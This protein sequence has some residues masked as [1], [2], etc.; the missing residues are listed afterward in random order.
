MNLHAESE[1]AEALHRRN[2]LC[3]V[4]DGPVPNGHVSGTTAT[5]E[6]RG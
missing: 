3:I 6:R 1:D 2:M 5:G 4:L